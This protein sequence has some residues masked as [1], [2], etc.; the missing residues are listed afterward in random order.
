MSEDNENTKSV[1]VTETAE[2]AEA[3]TESANTVETTE[4]TKVAETKVEPSAKT[5]KFSLLIRSCNSL[6]ILNLCL[7]SFHQGAEDQSNLEFVVVSTNDAS[8]EAGNVKHI[9]VDKNVGATEA[10]NLAA[11]KATG[12]VFWLLS[13]EYLCLTQD[14]DRL[15]NEALDSHNDDLAYVM[16]DDNLHSKVAGVMEKYGCTAPLVTKKSYDKLGCVFT[17]EVTGGG[18]D[19]ATFNVWNKAKPEC[20]IN[21]S[22]RVQLAYLD[23]NK[24]QTVAGRSELTDV[25]INNYVNK[26]AN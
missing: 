11:S 7:A 1:E 15:L 12:D 10:L 6:P 23:K 19:T 14:W 3:K 24:W 2:T 4:A 22:D 9:K 20:V 16:V 13:D 5:R 17:P 21:L 26:L 18:A 25:E 8:Q